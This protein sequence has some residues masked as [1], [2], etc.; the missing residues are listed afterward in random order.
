MGV[1]GA[2]VYHQAALG[3]DDIVLRAGPNASHGDFDRAE[4]GGLGRQL[5]MSQDVGHL[6]G[7]VYGIAVAT[8]IGACGVASDAGDECVDDDKTFLGHGGTHPGGFADDGCVDMRQQ[9]AQDL[10]AS[11]TADFLLRRGGDDDIVGGVCPGVRLHIRGY[12]Q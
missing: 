12:G 6:H 7:S 3:G 11:A 8:V 2:H 5:E 1:G 4:G 9:A 10:H